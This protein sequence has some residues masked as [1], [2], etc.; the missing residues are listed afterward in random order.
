MQKFWTRKKNEKQV[1]T[2]SKYKMALAFGAVGFKIH[3]VNR[4][5]L[6]WCLRD[7]PKERILCSMEIPI[8]YPL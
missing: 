2:S 3:L 8:K 6:A 1:Q 4:H 5:I 7:I